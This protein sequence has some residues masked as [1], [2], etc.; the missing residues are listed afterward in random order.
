[1]VSPRLTDGATSCHFRKSLSCNPDC[2]SIDWNV[3]CGTSF[4]AIFTTTVRTGF[5][6]LRNLACD[7]FCDTKK[8]PFT[9]R[10]LNTLCN[11]I[12]LGMLE[13]KRDQAW[14]LY[15][16]YLGEWNVLKIQFQCL[17]QHL[18]CFFSGIAKAGNTGVQIPRDVVFPFFPNDVFEIDG[19]HMLL[20]DICRIP[21]KRNMS[22]RAYNSTIRF[23]IPPPPRLSD[24]VN[25]KYEMNKK[26]LGMEKYAL[27][28]H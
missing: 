14:P 20:V 23:S 25:G 3:P 17:L 18:K 11:G 21:Q 16:V 6:C 9:L 5:P 12:G 13:F 2:N 1:M 7:P 27:G 24:G 28:V 4:F 26:L 8:K 15:L 10:T 22:N 19:S